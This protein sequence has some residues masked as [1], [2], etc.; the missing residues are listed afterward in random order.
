ME[1]SSVTSSWRGVMVEVAGGFVARIDE[2]ASSAA[3]RL[4]EVRRI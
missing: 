3:V 4:R 2:A 1:S